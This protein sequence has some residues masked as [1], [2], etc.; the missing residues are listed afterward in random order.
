MI[1]EYHR[2]T[3]LS[4]SIYIYAAFALQV[5]PFQQSMQLH[6]FWEVH[7]PSPKEWSHNQST[8][9]ASSSPPP[10]LW[11]LLVVLNQGDASHL[12]GGFKSAHSSLPLFLTPYSCLFL[13][14]SCIRHWCASFVLTLTE[15]HP[16]GKTELLQFNA[17]EPRCG[18]IALVCHDS[19]I[20]LLSYPVC[21]TMPCLSP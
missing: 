3:D 9:C 8:P 12:G 17:S 11:E 5:L 15:E 14:F 7:K 18:S 2:G 19:G 10:W 6:F 13:F 1:D 16:K 4:L 20:P 21:C